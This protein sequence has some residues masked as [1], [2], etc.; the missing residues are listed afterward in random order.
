MSRRHIFPALLGLACTLPAVTALPAPRPEAPPVRGSPAVDAVVGE[1]S[2]V[3]DRVLARALGALAPG[4][5]GADAAAGNLAYAR[6]IIQGITAQAPFVCARDRLDEARTRLQGDTL[7]FAYHLEPLYASLT[8][9]VDEAPPIGTPV[10]YQV[11]M[12]EEKAE[13]GDRTDAL[14]HLDAARDLLG[15]S[16]AYLPLGTLG[17]DLDAAGQALGQGDRAAAARAL[18][19]ARGALGPLPARADDPAALLP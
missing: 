1:S 2:R 5:A 9:L 8:D 15:R 18:E 17:A 19:H 11:R 16:H 6:S 4:G 14:H 13:E 3:L 10:M 12:A 7:D